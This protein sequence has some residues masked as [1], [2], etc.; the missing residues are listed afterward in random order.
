MNKIG[1]VGF[2]NM[3][4]TMLNALLKSGAIPEDRIIV[5]T[6]TREKLKNFLSSYKKVE[7]AKSLSDLGSKC[8]YVF[9][10]T[11]TKEVKPVLTE[12]VRFLPEDAYVISIAGTIEIK[13][14]ESIFKGRISKIMPTMICEVGE[15]VT[16]VCH[17]SKVLPEDKEFINTTFGNISRVKEIGENQFD[18]GADLTSCSPAFYAAILENLVETARKHGDFNE[19]DL[20]S[21]V[22]STCYGTVKLLMTGNADFGKLILRV[23]TKGGI[24][25]EGVKIL[26][27]RLPKVFDELLTV[28]LDKRQ[29][30]KKLMREQYGLE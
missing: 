25:E 19:D 17:N 27:N 12:L 15:G 22:L 13:C 2:G 28:T 24:S 20:K 18:L 29:K 1:F 30:T 5:F 23:A 9:I 26:N 8:K 11:S 14:L 4:G 6:R 21:L 3:G 16:L 10:C 7:V